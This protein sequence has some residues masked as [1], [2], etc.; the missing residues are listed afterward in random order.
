MTF[1]ALLAAFN[2]FAAE[3]IDTDMN[4]QDQKNTGVHKLS[5]KE[6]AALQRWIDANY[7]KKEPGEAS[8]EPVS[9]EGHPTLSENLRGSQYLRLSDNTLW[10]VRPEDVPIAQGWITPAEIIVTQSSNPFFSYKLTN[11]ITGSSVNA[12]KVNK[13]PPAGSPPLAPNSNE[14]TITLPPPHPPENKTP[15]PQSAAQPEQKK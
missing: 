3:A 2:I 5:D 9:A 4:A 1:L 12:R 7:Q 14:K 15:P 6:K 11:K 10:Y 8:A 13:L